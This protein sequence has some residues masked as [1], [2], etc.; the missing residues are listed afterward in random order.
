M[1]YRVC[2]AWRLLEPEIALCWDPAPRLTI[3]RNCLW[4]RIHLKFKSHLATLKENHGQPR[5]Q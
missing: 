5:I 3:I 1:H 2:G 4:V